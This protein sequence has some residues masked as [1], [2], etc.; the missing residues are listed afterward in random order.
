MASSPALALVALLVLSV[1]WI[2][3]YVVVRL[4]W[5]PYAIAKRLRGQGI[6][7]P[8]YKFLKGSNEE[9]KR[10]K[11]EV[12][13]LVL[14]VHN[15]NYLPRIAPHFLKWRTQYG[16]RFC[17]MFLNIPWQGYLVGCALS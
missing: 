17:L 1:A 14:D 5:R 9:V 10:M 12:S 13:G 7:G 4:I 11:W 2:W 6:H 15:H 3:E 8:P 16:K